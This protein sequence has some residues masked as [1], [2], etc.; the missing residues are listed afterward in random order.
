MA[1]STKRSDL[2]VRIGPAAERVNRQAEVLYLTGWLTGVLF[3]AMFIAA[4]WRNIHWLSI[5]ALC[6]AFGVSAVLMVIGTVFMYRTQHLVLDRYG[7]PR[8]AKPRL[9]RSALR[10]PQEF[11][12]WLTRSGGKLTVSTD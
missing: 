11:D 5:L 12:T 8:N 9:P 10:N 4:T 3:L 1:R 2:L 7:L 6:L